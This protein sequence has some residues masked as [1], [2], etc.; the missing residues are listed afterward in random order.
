MSRRSR[1]SRIIGILGA[2]VGSL[3]FASM[4][5]GQTAPSGNMEPEDPAPSEA[6]AQ[7]DTP[8]SPL[9]ASGDLT[10]ASR[11]L[12]QGFDYSDGQAVV[13]PN[14]SVVF[15]HLTANI[16]GNYQVNLQ[17]FNEFDFSLKVDQTFGKLSASAGYVNLQ[18]PNRP[19][20]EPSQEFCLDLGLEAA[21]SPTLSVHYDFDKG[22]GTYTTLGL[23]HPIGSSVSLATN[24]FYQ[25]RYYEVT[26][27]PAAEFKAS[28][29][30]S[31]GA[32][33]FTPA[34]SYFATWANGDFKDGGA[35]PSNWLFALNVARTF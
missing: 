21:F 3:A 35:V 20:W 24:V 12:F 10:V 17:E 4:A 34:L 13:Q 32:Y 31:L 27:F 30:H 1:C 2:V 16:W 8:V 6:P 23:S 18:Y 9:S 5:F 25:G 29:E 15:R 28:W 7:S 26:G 14:A 22:K 19:T 33:T 11:Y